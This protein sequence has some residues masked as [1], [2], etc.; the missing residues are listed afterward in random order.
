MKRCS[1]CKAVKPADTENFNNSRATKDKLSRICRACNARRAGAYNA[2][3]V[4][5]AIAHYGGRC[6]CCGT[7]RPEFLMLVST[8]KPD[9]S[10]SWTGGGFPMAF[11]LRQQGWPA[12]HR[13]LCANCRLA[14]SRDAEHTCL[15]AAA[16]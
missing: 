16:A 2:R 12:G 5:E 14:Q 3:V 11:R 6:A 1:D 4:A 13:V 8:G 9:R 15:S 10:G 7:S